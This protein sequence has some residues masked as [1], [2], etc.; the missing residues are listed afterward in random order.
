M[1]RDEVGQE[2]TVNDVF[3]PYLQECFCDQIRQ[4]GAE[5]ACVNTAGPIIVAEQHDGTDNAPL[6]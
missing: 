5:P 4:V 6:R 3:S 2:I 1:P